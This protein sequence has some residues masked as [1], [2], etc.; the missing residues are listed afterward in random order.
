MI[1]HQQIDLN[2]M[3]LFV[4]VVR[5]G[6]LSKASEWLHIPKSRL[7]RRLTE[8]E[9][10]LGTTLIDR[11][12]KGVRLNEVGEKFF[13]QAQEML[14]YAE[15]AINAVQNSLET[16]NGR[17]KITIST[18]IL[19]NILAP[20]L[21][22]FLALYPQISLDIQT[23][24]QN[25]NMLQQGIDIAFRIGDPIHHDI[26]ARQ[27]KTFQ[28]GLYATRHYL[29]RYGI[30]H[31]PEALNHHQLLQKDDG[32]AWILHK[33]QQTFHVHSPKRVISNDFNL[34]ERL[35]ND[36]AG[37]ALL[38]EYYAHHSNWQQ[39]LTDWQIEPVPLHLLYYKNR[40][41]VPVIRAFVQFIIDKLQDETGNE[42]G[43]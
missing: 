25:I 8:L 21:A 19:R 7:S 6:S 29:E 10:Q 14:A 36:H 22:E 28:L 9:Q 18:E 11:S 27:L 16:P 20:Y 39:L 42:K 24:N 37:I 43:R 38:P 23:Q 34:L 33:Q 13:E 35:V 30:P 5:A 15:Q 31:Q 17:L 26:V 1:H 3:R 12:R 40:G 41:S 4:A 32:P 2:D